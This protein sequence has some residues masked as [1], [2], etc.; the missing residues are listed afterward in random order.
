MQNL[1]THGDCK[2]YWSGNI[3]VVFSEDSRFPSEIQWYKSTRTGFRYETCSA[4]N[5]FMHCARWFFTNL[6]NWRN[7]QQIKILSGCSLSL[8]LFL[9]PFEWEWYLGLI[10][11]CISNHQK[12]HFRDSENDRSAFQPINSWAQKRVDVETKGDISEWHYTRSRATSCCF[13]WTINHQSSPHS[14]RLHISNKLSH[15]VSPGLSDRKLARGVK[16]AW[17]GGFPSSAV[18]SAD[19]TPSETD[20]TVYTSKASPTDWTEEVSFTNTL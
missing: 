19:I 5:L 12:G 11:G 20:K 15:I 13:D 10:I 7:K 18:F 2:T 3:I 8:G 9:K 17:V 14:T 4:Q 1:C 16:K 6:I